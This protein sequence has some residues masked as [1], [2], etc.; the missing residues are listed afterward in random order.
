MYLDGTKSPKEVKG[1]DRKFENKIKTAIREYL[2]NMEMETPGF[3]GWQRF[4][5]LH[6]E[7]FEPKCGENLETFVVAVKH[8][9]VD[10]MNVTVFEIWII[11]DEFV[12][13][14]FDGRAD[15]DFNRKKVY[16]HNV[17][18]GTFTESHADAFLGRMLENVCEVA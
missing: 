4:S 10:N 5:I 2:I 7:R 13:A 17:C 12:L 1:M 6:T 11:N 3:F 15:I 9:S 18:S 14:L 16:N 8:K